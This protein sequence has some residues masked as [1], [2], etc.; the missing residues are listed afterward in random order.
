MERRLTKSAVKI[1]Q[2][3]EAAVPAKILAKAIVDLSSA[4]VKLLGS[5]LTEDAIVVLLH[6]YTKL[7]RTDIRQVL[8]ALPQLAAV[9]TK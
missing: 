2:D 7:S 6:D 8:R 3:P 9:Y 5:G 4:A 1:V